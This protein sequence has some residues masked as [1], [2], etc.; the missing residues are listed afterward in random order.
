MQLLIV[1]DDRSIREMLRM[2]V[3]DMDCYVVGEADN[4]RSGI[5]EAERLQPQVMLLDVSMPF[6]GGFDAA[7]T[8]KRRL[9]ELRIIFVSQ[10]SER[11]YAEEAFRCGAKG[12]VL[13]RAA[14]TELPNA[15]R[16]VMSGQV[17]RSPLT[18]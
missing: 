2:L 6:M 7:R 3:Q 1:D 9:P 15:I 14:A 5:D 11:I 18:V 17:F 16:A 12:Y 8:L 13:K 10:H 4:G